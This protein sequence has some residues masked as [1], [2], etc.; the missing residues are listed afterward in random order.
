[1]A[2]HR[3]AKALRMI[4]ERWILWCDISKTVVQKQMLD[5]LDALLFQDSADL[6]PQPECH[7]NRVQAGQQ[8]CASISCFPTANM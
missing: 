7:K 6:N 5:T 1:M 2:Q 8:F 3:T 4:D